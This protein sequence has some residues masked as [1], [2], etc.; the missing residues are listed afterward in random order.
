MAL[1]PQSTPE[2][3]AIILYSA[4]VAHMLHPATAKTFQGY[5]DFVFGPYISSQIH[6]TSCVDV[7]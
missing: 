1:K 7:V 6:K 5:A 3:D 4:V 2:V